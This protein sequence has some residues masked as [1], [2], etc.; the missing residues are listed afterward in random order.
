MA[1]RARTLRPLIW[2]LLVLLLFTPLILEV[3]FVNDLLA[4]AQ[5]ALTF[6]DDK[7]E[8]VFLSDILFTEAA[9]LIL[10]GALIAGAVLYT[11]WAS[12]DVRQVQFT[13]SIWSWKRMN[14]ERNSS[15]GLR[16]GLTIL[17]VGIIYVVAAVVISLPSI[18]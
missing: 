14:E 16:E 8:L 17:A 13:E 11:S 10:L 9:V 12:L 6:W 4:F 7:T 3:V 5:R 1:I 2:V 18:S 15:I